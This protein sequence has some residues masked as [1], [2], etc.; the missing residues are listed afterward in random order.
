MTYPIPAGGRGRVRP[1]PRP[2]GSRLWGSESASVC[3][4]GGDPL[5]VG[6][7]HVQRLQ[8]GA[9][10]EQQQACLTPWDT[11]GEPLT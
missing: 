10:G 2:P 5:R 11:R 7:G 3:Q 8:G 1:Q 9:A 6:P 4:E